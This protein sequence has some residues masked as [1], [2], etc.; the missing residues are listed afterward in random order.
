MKKIK[1][2]KNKKDKNNK[3]IKKTIKKQIL[4]TLITITILIIF[5]ITLTSC[6]NNTNTLQ[7]NKNKN[8]TNTI[9][10][11]DNKT[12]ITNKK[13]S[14]TYNNN[15]IQNTT[16][17][18]QNNTLNTT[19]KVLKEKN[20]IKQKVL[21]KPKETWYWQ[22]EGKI[23]LSKNVK[24]YDVDLFKITKEE[25]KKLHEKGIKVICYFNAGAYEDYRND[26]NLFPKTIIGKTLTEWKDEKWIDIRKINLIE[27]I[28]TERMNIAVEK[29]CDAI[30]PDNIE[31]YQNPTG[32]KITYEDQIKY[33]KYLAEEA[34]KRNLSIALKN[35]IEQIKDLIDYYDLAI[36]EQCFEYE[37]CKLL[38]PF[39]KQDKAVLGVEYNLKL[40]EF[41]KKAE[42]YNFSWLKAEYSLNG[43]TKS[44]REYLNSK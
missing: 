25:I 28:I 42:E 14:N 1:N 44:C 20:V 23:N 36:N 21:F 9:K 19:K 18:I 40:K 17:Q 24:I 43:T 41:C 39:I 6:T 7:K 15:K 29:N 5:I 16:K 35:D 27:P 4:T 2:K 38:L 34:H 11:Q 30:E 22:L 12:N 3:K 26:S 37:E 31:G 8:I 10:I 13:I 33:N 32:F